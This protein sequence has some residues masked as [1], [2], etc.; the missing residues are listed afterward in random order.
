MASET[1]K[2]YATFDVD[3]TLFRVLESD[4]AQYTGNVLYKMYVEGKESTTPIIV[5]TDKDIFA[6][7]INY[8]RKL[9]IMSNSFLENEYLVRGVYEEALKFQLLELSCKMK[10]I[11][12]I[13]DDECSTE[14]VET[15]HNLS[16]VFRT[17]LEPLL[18]KY[19]KDMF[20]LN[21][22]L[23]A[24]IKLDPK[25]SKIRKAVKNI[26]GWSSG[27]KGY[28]D[29][30]KCYFKEII[31]TTK[32]QGTPED[33]ELTKIA[34]T[35]LFS[36]IKEDRSEQVNE[37]K[38]LSGAKLL[39]VLNEKEVVPKYDEPPKKTTEPIKT[40]EEILLKVTK[41]LPDTV[42]KLRN[43]NHEELK[44][45]LEDDDKNIDSLSDMISTGEVFEDIKSISEMPEYPNIHKS[46][47]TNGLKQLAKVSEPTKKKPSQISIDDSSE[48]ED[49][50]L[51]I[52]TMAQR[53]RE[54]NRDSDDD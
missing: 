20:Q 33:V 38:Y 14:W 4:L 9:P 42:V 6:I 37:G 53:F 49:D 31:N 35:E 1:V 13:N 34:Y 10:E 29:L 36:P 23:D 2:K 32:E 15:F 28:S 7:I 11:I 17:Y 8:L 26:F 43:T 39:S 46:L 41:N 16:S 21:I 3:G 51:S 54:K 5:I 44:K 24:L 48:D 25:D 19:N 52:N 50:K 40:K 30:F 12:D 27:S 47:L 18:K 22:F 45:K